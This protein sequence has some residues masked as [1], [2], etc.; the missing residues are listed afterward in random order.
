MLA[1]RDVSLSDETVREGCLKFGQTYANGQRRKSPRPGDRWH[2]DEVFLKING[3]IHYLWRAV[4]QDGDVLDILVQS[5]RDRKAAKKFFRKLLKGLQYVPQVI[6]TDQLRSYSAA[7]TAMLP[8]VE[9]H[10]QKYQNNRAE[11]SHQPT[12]LRE[13]V[14]R[15]FKSAG[16]AQRFLSAFG[17]INSHF[18]VGR[19]FVQRWRLS[20]SKEAETCQ[21]GRSD[22][23]DRASPITVILKL[24]CDQ[25]WFD[26]YCGYRAAC[27]ES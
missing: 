8:S 4:D 14:M 15:R 9:H 17:I 5:K 27:S 11:N 23:V 10:Q 12:R 26:D 6:I 25:E 21:L 7:K 24:S 16:H 18:R 3:R 20:H 13:R 2:L 19:H 1:M 22:C